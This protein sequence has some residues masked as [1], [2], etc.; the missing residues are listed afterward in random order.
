MCGI[1]GV[2]QHEGPLQ[3]DVP[4]LASALGAALAHRGP[5]G[6]GTWVAPDAEGANVLL[7]HRRLAIIDPGP[8]GSQP[9]SSPDG[10]FRIVFNVFMC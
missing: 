6:A 2:I 9:M 5:D 7:V 3:G 10:R 8:G 1:A 4:A